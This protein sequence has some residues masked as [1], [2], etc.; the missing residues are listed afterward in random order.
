MGLIDVYSA[1]FPDLKF[2]PGLHVH[3][4]EKVLSIADGLPKYADMPVEPGG[5]GKELAD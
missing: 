1:M 4:G 5:S 2:E 3:C